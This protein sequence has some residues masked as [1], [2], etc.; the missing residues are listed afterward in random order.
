MDEA[1]LRDLT[2]TIHALDPAHTVEY[3]DTLIAVLL[4]VRAELADE[5][6]RA[7]THRCQGCGCPVYPLPGSGLCTACLEA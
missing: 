4:R 1:Q 5:P 7:S 3:L 2:Q 6:A